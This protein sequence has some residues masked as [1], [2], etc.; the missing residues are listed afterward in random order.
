[1]IDYPPMSFAQRSN[2]EMTSYGLGYGSSMH[3][4]EVCAL[5]FVAISTCMI[6]FK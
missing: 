6:F 1:M 2:V 4:L 5:E 3:I